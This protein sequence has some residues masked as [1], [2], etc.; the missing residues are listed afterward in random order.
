MEPL[1]GP[2]G[3][4]FEH[5]AEVREGLDAVELAGFDD[6]VEGR[7]TLSAVELMLSHYGISDMN[8]TVSTLCEFFSREVPRLSDTYD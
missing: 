7:G 2:G 6:A 3:E 1:V 8:P 4:F 5:I